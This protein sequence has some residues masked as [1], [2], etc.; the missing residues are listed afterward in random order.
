M[1]LSASAQTFFPKTD[2]KSE[3]KPKEKAPLKSS[4][5]VDVPEFV[6]NTEKNIQPKEGNQ[7]V[8]KNI[9]K[10]QISKKD[11]NRIANRNDG[12]EKKTQNQRNILEKQ[13]FNPRHDIN[14]A[15]SKDIK[16]MSDLFSAR[17]DKN[18]FNHIP[19]KSKQ[20]DSLRK[21]D[22]VNV[23]AS[24]NK[25]NH[26][27]ELLQTYSIGVSAQS[28][29]R[30]QNKK[31][32]TGDDLN[33]IPSTSWSSIV[34]TA[35]QKKTQSLDRRSSLTPNTGHSQ[36][37]R[38]KTYD[39][40]R[41]KRNKLNKLKKTNSLLG[42]LGDPV[43]TN[44]SVKAKSL[45][46]R[47]THTHLTESRSV[48]SNDIALRQARP[49]LEI[50][51]KSLVL[52]AKKSAG[53]KQNPEMDN[54]FTQDVPAKIEL[55]STLT[56]LSPDDEK[57]PESPKPS[58]TPTEK[59]KLT[60][61]TKKVFS[62]SLKVTDFTDKIV[63]TKHDITDDYFSNDKY[64]NLPKQDTTKDTLELSKKPLGNDFNRP[65][66]VSYSAM[67][68]KNS[69]G[70]PVTSKPPEKEK[71]LL[72]SEEIRLMKKAKKKEKKK[73]K[74]QKRIAESQNQQDKGNHDD[75]AAVQD[76]TKNKSKQNMTIDIS[77]MVDKLFLAAP[78]TKSNK[79]SRNKSKPK[80]VTVSTGV[81]SVVSG[82]AKKNKHDGKRTTRNKYGGTGII[83]DGATAIVK[84]GKER[85]TPKR[86]KPTLLK[87]IIQAERERKRQILLKAQKENEASEEEQ[88]NVD[89]DEDHSEEK[90]SKGTEKERVNNNNVNSEK[91]PSEEKENTNKETSIIEVKSTETK[92][93]KCCAPLTKL[94]E[95]YWKQ[96]HSRKFREYCDHM[97]TKEINDLTYQLLTTLL[98]F[99]DRVYHENPTKFRQKRRFVL[100][101]RE[102]LKHTKLRRI[103]AVIVA[104]NL[105][106][107]SS[108]GGLDDYLRSILLL[109]DQDEIPKI[110]AMSRHGLGKT[111]KKKA[112]V[113]VIGIFN[114]DGAQ[115]TYKELINHVEN[116]KKLYSDKVHAILTQKNTSKTAS[117]KQ[118][119]PKDVGINK[120]SN[121]SPSQ[122][123]ES[124]HR[125]HQSPRLQ[126]NHHNE[127]EMLSHQILTKLS[128][129]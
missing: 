123:S 12:N 4:L 63:S 60:R 69:A 35:P 2:S 44:P 126:N 74:K 103:K 112:P 53:L 29:K 97:A 67:L 127:V 9:I 117:Q 34:K 22:S 56:K 113:S 13:S 32:A 20:K 47:L 65:A 114:Y 41:D 99:Q 124:N 50:K 79:S 15:Q 54:W 30:V 98:R 84:R 75:G 102:V 100:G 96:L 43:I 116:A 128:E 85:E 48:G 93:I 81:V 24:E 82:L 68:K 101:L 57:P 129:P 45:P 46:K 121:S 55:F 91:S 70:P 120:S 73:M 17:H 10:K 95:E 37:F 5:S 23:Y 61:T 72:T 27:K 86:K 26:H 28:K 92:E 76:K 38:T 21:S 78:K 51:R 11:S 122:S 71:K 104:P 119:K 31:S 16:E 106:K 19:A 125:S 49:R 66:V 111:L 25:D 36:D 109:C 39:V 115:D 90:A 7:E 52:K 83:M 80:K 8:N 110:F 88:K 64:K 1:A 77:D 87:K 59:R 108:E 58:T 6:P 3:N 14:W 118:T 107:I 62:P 40:E 18:W 89:D 94:P 105:E 33:N 42:A